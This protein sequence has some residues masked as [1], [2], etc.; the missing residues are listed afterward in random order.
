MLLEGKP[1]NMW[2]HERVARDI[3]ELQRQLASGTRVAVVWAGIPAYFSDFRM[4]DV[5]GYNDREIAK[6][7]WFQRISLDHADA[8]LPGHMKHNLEYTL[9]EKQPDVLFQ[10]WDD[11][12]ERELAA[13]ESRGYFLVR[14]GEPIQDTA[15]VMWL[16]GAAHLPL[17]WPERWP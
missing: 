1:Y 4:I 14:T 6:G 8:Y 11:W 3:H 2:A 15:G 12:H 13:L 9:A 16:R 7:P 5:M 17:R 10:W